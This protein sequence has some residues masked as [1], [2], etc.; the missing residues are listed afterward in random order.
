M[1]RKRGSLG[2]SKN[3]VPSQ[4]KIKKKYKIQERKR[5][6]EEERVNVFLEVIGFSRKGYV[7][8]EKT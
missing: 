8:R 6:R 2:K 4:R 7:H 1:K 3:K 5:E